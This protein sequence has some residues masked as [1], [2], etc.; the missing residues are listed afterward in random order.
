MHPVQKPGQE[1]A[2]A[3]HAVLCNTVGKLPFSDCVGPIHPVQSP[4]IGSQLAWLAGLTKA[5]TPPS[6]L[7]AKGFV[8]VQSL[9]TG[10]LPNE[11]GMMH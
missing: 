10:R 1:A 9:D 8:H 11:G 7:H 6:C 5:E 2:H 4:E 3:V